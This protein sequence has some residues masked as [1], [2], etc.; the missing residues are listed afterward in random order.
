M[1]A[2]GCIPSEL[3]TEKLVF[4][5]IT[6]EIEAFACEDAVLSSHVALPSDV[7]TSLFTNAVSVALVTC[8]GI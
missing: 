4:S 1:P 8:L 3:C 5:R 6:I 2:M 7:Y